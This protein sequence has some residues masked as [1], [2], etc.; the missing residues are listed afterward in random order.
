M[1]TS[2]SLTAS[3]LHYA[4]AFPMMASIGAV[5]KAHTIEDRK[6]PDRQWW[7]RQHESFGLLTAIVLIPR[8]AHRILARKAYAVQDLPDATSVEKFL[9]RST[10]FGLHGFGIVLAG[11][12]VAMNYVSGW[13]LPF[14]YWTVPGLPKTPEN[15]EKYGEIAYRMYNVHNIVGSYGKYLI[16]LH[17]VG[18]LKHYV[19]GQAFSHVS[20]R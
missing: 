6:S 13:G 11:T 12:G 9:A 1:A 18:T 15:K 14:F 8:V 10:Y 17:I 16:P 20:I 5:L 19:A 4:V 2:Y 7:M 3:W